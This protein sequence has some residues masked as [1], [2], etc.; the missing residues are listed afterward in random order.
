[1]NDDAVIADFLERLDTG[2]VDGQLNVELAKLSYS[3]LLMVSKVFAERSVAGNGS[4]QIGIADTLQPN[5]ANA[6]FHIA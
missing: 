4:K 3:Q 1:M 2:Q 6:E 5:Q